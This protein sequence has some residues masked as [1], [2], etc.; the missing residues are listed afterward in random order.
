M[1][2]KSISKLD[3]IIG[4]EKIYERKLIT[5]KS[6]NSVGEVIIIVTNGRSITIKENEV[7]SFISKLEAPGNAKQILPAKINQQHKIIINGYNP[8]AENVALKKSLMNVLEELSKTT[9]DAEIKKARAICD[10][11]N[12]MVNIQ[13]AEIQL[14]NTIK[15]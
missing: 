13:K 11:A 2:N 14:I 1:R 8:S 5:I 15:K 12:T 10:V 3:D 6:Y 4:I 7:D 9:T